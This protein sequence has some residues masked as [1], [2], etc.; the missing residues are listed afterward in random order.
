MILK[1]TFKSVSNRDVN[2]TFFFIRFAQKSAK[3]SYNRLKL[4]PYEFSLTIHE[5]FLTIFNPKPPFFVGTFLAFHICR[6]SS[7]LYIL[8]PFFFASLCSF[9]S[10]SNQLFVFEVFFE[11]SEGLKKL[12]GANVG[13][14]LIIFLPRNHQLDPFTQAFFEWF[15]VKRGVNWNFFVFLNIFLME[16]WKQFFY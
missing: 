14:L 13:K 6:I 12:R 4:N 15:A 2:P 7:T 3:T 10:N 1:L 11:S 9:S 16:F 5:K 8:K